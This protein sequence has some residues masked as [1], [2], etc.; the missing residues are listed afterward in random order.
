MREHRLIFEF[1]C[2][3]PKLKAYSVWT[4]CAG[5]GPVEHT[6]SIVNLDKDPI[7]LPKQTS[8]AWSF[9]PAKGHVLDS[10]WVEKGAGRP[11]NAGV[12]QTNLTPDIS[13]ELLTLPYV[14]DQRAYSENGN[15]RDP[16]PWISVVDR[17]SNS[18]WYAGIEFSGRTS[19][20]L[21]SRANESVAVD[22]G[23]ADEPKGLPEFVTVIGAGQTYVLPTVFIGCF[24]G[25]V[26]VGCNSLRRW[27]ATELRPKSTNAN[28][29]L[30]TLNSW[31]SGMA[32]DTPLGRS[33]MREAAGLGLEMFH[34]DAGWF[35]GV[36]DWRSN[37]AKFP[38]GIDKIA[39]DAHSLGL[40]FGLWVGWTQGGIMSE[41]VDRGAVI[42]VHSNDRSSWFANDYAADWKPAD[43]VGADL[44]LAE[45]KASKWCVDLLTRLV[46]EYHI[47]MLEHDQRMIVDECKRTTHSHTGSQ[48]DIAYH[49]TLGYYSVYDGLRKAYPDLM[50]ENCVNG[51]RMVDF[52]AARRAHYFSIADSYFPLANR[53]AFWDT[54]Y[55]MP[56]SMCEC[57]VM[58]VPLKSLDEFIG[59]LRSG[60][61]G[62]CTIMQDP[63]KWTPEQHRVA[64]RE[65]E[66]YKKVLRP[67]ILNADLYHVSDR[68]DGVRWDGVQYV[69]PDRRTGVIYAF[70]GENDQP[71]HSFVL[72]GLMPERKYR[73]H[74]QDGGQAD[75][76]VSGAELMGKGIV[77]A[78]SS[79]NTSQLV[80]IASA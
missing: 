45:P 57:Y 23:L 69:M 37:P 18:G 80:L 3:S 77:V 7:A 12:H 47:D 29:P 30:L 32:I 4:G 67:M 70:R 22:L 61:M 75:C 6:L 14:T 72:K 24:T 78:L 36:G 42:N 76:T 19:I 52:G 55:V 11:S 53:R 31:G 71:T 60:M 15:E 20:R 49:A 17:S 68:P 64:K 48:G 54:S 26:E 79:P 63:A 34:V 41:D 50:F 35:Q 73:L 62:W 25:D 10:W 65:F 58:E 39:N 13:Q 28:Y 38:E 21:N 1:A 74:F 40:K 16:I 59:M 33:M 5:Q 2:V 51:G 9:V 46:K 44:C 66:T 8:L 43:F 27:V 56:P